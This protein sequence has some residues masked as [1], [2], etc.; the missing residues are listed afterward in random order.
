MNFVNFYKRFINKFN[1]IT[2]FFIDILKKSKKEKF[3]ENLKL[4][5]TT[6]KAFKNVFFV[7]SILLHFDFKRKIKV[8]TNVSKFKIFNIINQ[9]IQ[10]TV[11]WH[12]IAFLFKKKC[13]RNKLRRKKIENVDFNK[14]MQTMKTLFKKRRLLN[15]NL[16]KSF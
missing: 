8:K 10:F 4:T 12:F 1:S 16:Q 5:S 14:K 6:K 9:L 15:V 7:A 11:Q 13:R 3:F 2:L